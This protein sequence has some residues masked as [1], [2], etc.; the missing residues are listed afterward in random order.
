M[1]EKPA[2]A[3]RYTLVDSLRGLAALAVML[4]HFT[5]GRLTQGLS[6]ALGEGVVKLAREG[7]VGVEVFF[8]L[9][10]FVIAHSVG[11][12]PVSL[13]ESG[14][15][16]LRRQVRLDPPYWVSIVLALLPEWISVITHRGPARHSVGDIAAHVAYLHGVLQ[17]RPIQPVYWTLAIEVQLYLVFILG[18][19]ALG[20][21]TR[22]APYWLLA[23]VP[24]SLWVAMTFAIPKYFFVPHFYLFALGALAWW[25][26]T[27]GRALWLVVLPIALSLVAWR[28]FGRL[29]PLAGALTAVVLVMAGRRN[30]LSRWLSARPLVWLGGV[31]YGV[32]LTHTLAGGQALW[33]V[34]SRVGLGAVG[35]SITLV[36]AIALSLLVGWA[37]KHWVEDPAMRLARRVSWR[38]RES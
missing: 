13:G 32:Y 2:G 8:V 38:R 25:C 4:Y 26:A 22:S 30:A 37:L 33:H 34:G 1:S 9:S 3:G 36:S 19:W 11:E 28:K 31:S 14:R 15:F 6:L 10:G 12:K 27:R 7:W 5:G 29:E 21:R 18:V 16:A 35:A 23:T 20:S 24:V 17:L